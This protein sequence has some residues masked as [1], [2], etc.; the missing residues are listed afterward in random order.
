MYYNFFLNNHRFK[1]LVFASS[2][3]FIYPIYLFCILRGCLD[4]T[5]RH[6]LKMQPDTISGDVTIGSSYTYG[7]YRLSQH[8]TD[9]AKNIL[10]YTFMC[11]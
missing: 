4:Q 2:F 6:D 9:L 7:E 5:L 8:L 10:N 3:L 1:L 11:I